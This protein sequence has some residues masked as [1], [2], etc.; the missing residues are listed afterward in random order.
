MDKNIRVTGKGKLSVK[1]DTICLA[2]EA[3]DGYLDYEKTIEESAKQTKVLRESLEK[4]GLSG[5]DLKTKHFSIQA[6]YESY[7]DENDDYKSRF[8][9]YKFKHNTEIRFP[10]DNDQLGRT[11]YELSKC[12]VEVEFNI[13]YTVSDL[14]EVKNELL[15]K[16]VEDSKRKAKILAKSAGVNLGEIKRIDYSWGELEIFSHPIDDFMVRPMFSESKESYDIDIEAD[17][18]DVDDTVTIEWELL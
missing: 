8:V 11:L 7:R 6:A 14:E 10:N 4:S 1:P 16:A 5:K 12:P 17:D 18:I 13:Y 2:I 9:G 15:K 3:E